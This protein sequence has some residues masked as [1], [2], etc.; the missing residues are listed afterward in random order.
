M[1][2]V[3]RWALWAGAALVLG[4]GCEADREHPNPPAAVVAAAPAVDPRA[5]EAAARAERTR[6]MQAFRTALEARTDSARRELGQVQSLSRSERGQLRRDVNDPHVARA[7]ALGIRPA[8]ED[9]IA[10][11]RSAG[12]LVPLEDS[13]RYWTVRELNYSVPLVTPDAKA[14]LLELGRRFHERLD[15]AGLPPFR[16]EITSVLRTPKDQEELRGSNANAAEGHSAHEFGTTV[17]VAHVRFS[18]PDPASFPPPPAGTDSVLAA[19]MRAAETEA[20]QDAADKG[21]SALQAELGR[22]LMEMR[23]ENKLLV[24]MERRQAVYHMTV[25]RHLAR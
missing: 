24:M 22:V 25:A 10:R 9:E 20:L 4:A 2:R 18:P 13:T 14:M 11:L 16:M 17:D 1:P 21:A 8:D 19:A 15:S 3:S 23:E 12:R 6:E 5:V 7:R